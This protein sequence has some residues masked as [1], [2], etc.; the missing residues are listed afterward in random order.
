MVNS[1]TNRVGWRHRTAVTMAVVA[2]LY[3]LLTHQTVD[4]DWHSKDITHQVELIL[5]TI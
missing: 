4:V 5:G 3:L 2:L 1:I